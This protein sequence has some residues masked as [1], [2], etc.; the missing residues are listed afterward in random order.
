MKKPFFYF[1]SLSLILFVSVWCHA[2]S[3]TNSPVTTS[4]LEKAVLAEIN[5]ARENPQEYVKFL[6]EY[7]K[8]F[9]GNTVYLSNFLRIETKEG[10]AVVD[11]AIEFIKQ[12]PKL[13]PYTFSDGLNLAAAAH[14]K[15]LSENF[16]L[17]HKGKDGSL[18]PVR[19]NRF[20]KVTGALSENIAYF[21][22]TARDIVISWILDDGT[23]NRAHR[24]NIFSP[25]FKR[26]GISAGKTKNGEG[27]CIIDLAESF[28]DHGKGGIIEF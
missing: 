4:A 3:K 6:E 16:R 12:Q 28:S 1:V 22:E 7:K 13:S 26:I 19:L 5:F 8:L 21:T 25:K 9:K 23:P 10:T 20:G 15:D 18:P 14:M 27:L 17:G 11:E 2:Q 24:K